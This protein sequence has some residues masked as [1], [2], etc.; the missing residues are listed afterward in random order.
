MNLIV[1]CIF[2]KIMCLS[3][4]GNS[5][6]LSLNTTNSSNKTTMYQVNRLTR[7]QQVTAN[8]LERMALADGH[9]PAVAAQKMQNPIIPS[10]RAFKNMLETMLASTAGTTTEATAPVAAA[11]TTSTTN[12]GD[13]AGTTAAAD[14]NAPATTTNDEAI[15]M[16]NLETMP[17]LPMFMLSRINGQ[18]PVTRLTNMHYAHSSNMYIAAMLRIPK[19]PPSPKVSFCKSNLVVYEITSP[20]KPLAKPTMT[21]PTVIV[22]CLLLSMFSREC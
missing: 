15:P 11:A 19:A 20:T 9:H 14:A 17:P 21:M 13:N 18:C 22:L 3:H 7:Q 5:Q 2:V 6:P 12:T 4:E 1:T 10:P 8:A 16:A